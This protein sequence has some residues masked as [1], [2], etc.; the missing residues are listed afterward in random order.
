VSRTSTPDD[1]GE[2]LNLCLKSCLIAGDAA[3]SDVTRRHTVDPPTSAFAANGTVKR[4]D[5]NVPE[6]MITTI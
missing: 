5:D 1:G 6:V 4:R 3:A 2:T